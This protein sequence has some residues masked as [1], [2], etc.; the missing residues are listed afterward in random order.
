M[1]DQLRRKGIPLPSVK[2][3][4]A[5]KAKAIEWN[6]AYP[7]FAFSI[8][9]PGEKCESKNGVL[10]ILSFSQRPTA[11]APRCFNLARRHCI[12]P[13]RGRRVEWSDPRRGSERLHFRARRICRRCACDAS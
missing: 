3:C 1:T 6:E 12:S 13:R 5:A 9:S 7:D 2:E 10:E 4:K 11:Q 8:L